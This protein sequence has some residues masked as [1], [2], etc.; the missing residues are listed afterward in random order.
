VKSEI[1]AT[2]RA[3]IFV[4][5]AVFA[6]RA[7]AERYDLDQ[8]GATVNVPSEE[9]WFRRGGPQLPVGEFAVFAVNSTTKAHFGVAAIPG[10]PTNDVRHS[11]VLGRIMDIMRTMAFEPAR[12]RFG[13]HNGQNYVEVIGHHTTEGGEKF[14][15]VARG[16]LRNSFLFITIHARKGEDSEADQPEFM[17]HIETLGF[18]AVTSYS[19]FTI[20]TKIPQLIPWHYRAYRGAAILAGL[21]VLA[22][23]GMMFATRNRAR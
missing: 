7:W 18:D 17:A 6:D 13:E 21:L 22:F 2:L 5:A 15:S 11:T 23:A 3:A 4:L 8:Y 20:A 1:V 12:Q 9:G 14:V 16:I 10:Y 19:D